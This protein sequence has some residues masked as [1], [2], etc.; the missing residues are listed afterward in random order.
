MVRIQIS[1]KNITTSISNKR[2]TGWV[3]GKCSTE[4]ATNHSLP[5]NYFLFNG[6]EQK[7]V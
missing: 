5:E 6:L 2:I 7:R 1:F 4:S 3:E